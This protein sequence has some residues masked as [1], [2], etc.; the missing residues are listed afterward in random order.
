MKNILFAASECVPFIKTGGLADVVGAL[1]KALDNTRYDV[2]VVL[3]EYTAIPASWR[4]KMR[5]AHHFYMDL[6]ELGDCYV[7]VR[8][9]EVD[10]VTYYF[11]DNK[12]YFGGQT[13]YGNIKWDIEKFCFFSKAVLAILPVIGFHPDVIHC[14]DWQTG[15]V[16]VFLH[17]LF[18]ENPFFHGIRTVMTIHNLRFQGVWDIKTLKTCTGLPQWCFTPDRLEFKRDA[19][20]LKGGLVF[21]DR[22]T[23]VSE[24]Y[25]GEIQM[26]YY[27]EGLDGLLRAKAGTLSGIVNGIDYSVYDPQTDE[28]LYKTYSTRNFRKGKTAN[29]TA[30][31]Q[32]VGLPVDPD[33]MMIAMISRLTDQK[34]LDLVEWVMN[35]MLDSRIQFVVI[36]TGDSRYENLF[37]H[38]EWARRDKVSANIYFNDERAHRLY[39]AADAMLMPSAFEPCGLTQLISL[40]YGTVPI[41]RETGGLRDTV[42]PYNRFAGTGTGFSF[43]NYN[44]DEMLGSIFYAEQVFYDDRPAWDAMV[45][46]G[47]TTD[48]SWGRSAG[49][50]EALYDSLG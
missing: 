27:G 26:P 10:G 38:F 39:A 9:L 31:Q 49:K 42:E 14:H 1:P 25:A 4:E 3:P 22:I 40:R 12:H 5:Y 45:K 23:T 48:F 18:K 30:L 50:Y 6:G 33:V 28:K 17:T 35:R 13:P 21:A 46:R 19:N 8:T 43:S 47:M 24:T 44:A 34:G 2:R 15:L 37:R 36:G 20:M 11:I 16:P 29:K 41:V 32:E 7:G